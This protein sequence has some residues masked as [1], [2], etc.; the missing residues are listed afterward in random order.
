MSMVCEL[1][2]IISDSVNI[3]LMQ[4]GLTPWKSIIN[5]NHFIILLIGFAIMSCRGLVFTSIDQAIFGRIIQ[6]EQQLAGQN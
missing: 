3:F 2:I 4:T 5:F 6:L 1:L